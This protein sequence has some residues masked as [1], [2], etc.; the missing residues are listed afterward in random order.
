MAP[1]APRLTRRAVAAWT[2]AGGGAA[3][4]ACGRADATAGQPAAPSAAPRTLKVA[5]NTGGGYQLE[6]WKPIWAAW[7]RDHPN[8]KLDA[9]T[10]I[11]S[12]DEFRVK[13]LTALAGGT[14]YDALHIHHVLSGE[15][16]AK[17]LLQPLDQLIGKDREVRF[18]DFPTFLAAAYKWRGTQYGLPVE[19]N[20]GAYFYNT[21]LF[22]RTGA[23]TPTEHARAG[24]WTWEQ[25]LETA[26]ELTRGQGED[27]TWGFGQSSGRG[28]G[29][30]GWDAWMPVVWSNGGDIW[31]KDVT[32]L[33][34][35]SK[36]A[37]AGLQYYV[38]LINKHQVAPP[39]DQGPLWD[40][41]TGKIAMGLVKP[42][43][44]PQYKN[45]NW[46]PGM[47]VRPNGPAGAF[48]SAGSSMFGIFK[49]A[50]QRDDAWTWS[51]WFSDAGVRAVLDDGAFTAPPRKS[52]AQYKGWLASR[53]PWEDADVWAKATERLRLPLAVPGWDTVVNTFAK[54]F[55][56]ALLGKVGVADAVQ[57]AK[58]VI[59]Q[60]L[61]QEGVA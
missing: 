60:A 13:L 24:K 42:F 38:D 14:V 30:W 18:D 55:D 50:T 61:K 40:H 48:H 52:L 35:D 2:A 44:V 19:A 27:K 25:L 20:P 16:M 11:A 15:F 23:R 49:G 59:D 34:L 46:T 29:Y 45:Y 57:R 10:G 6:Q 33:A 22:A 47:V 9:M 36:E 39:V 53:Q 12:T 51:K 7:E 26:R 4:A 32:A 5:A 8:L 28:T 31:N 41:A 43:H 54:E 56:Q 3:L 21:E 58:P 1:G 17:N 37:I